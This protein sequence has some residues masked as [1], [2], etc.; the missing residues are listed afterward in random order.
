VST[1]PLDL[2]EFPADFVT[3]S[4]YKIFGFPTGLGALLVRRDSCRLLHKRYFGG[5]TV[6]GTVSRSGLHVP[7]LELHERLEDGTVP[8]LEILALE[9]GFQTL[10]RLAGPLSLVA[11]HTFSLAKYVHDEL[12]AMTHYNGAPVA[13]V[14]CDGDFSDPSVQGAILNF[15]L[16]RANGAYVG[17]SEVSDLASVHDIHLRTGCFCNTGACMTYL[18]MDTPHILRHMKAG[19]VCGDSIDLV[20]GRPTGSVRISFG[21]MSTLEDTKTF[22]SFIAH[23]FRCSSENRHSDDV[24]IRHNDVMGKASTGDYI[25][26]E[27]AVRREGKWREG[28]KVLTVG[29]GV[30]AFSDSSVSVA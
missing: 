16:L 17:Y 5:G 15:N 9:H 22:V 10:S 21:Y 8:F 3:I 30:V 29:A 27:D 18:R 24:I 11:E 28:E 20:D 26:A 13:V 6:F 7:R 1:N 14:Y 12:S 2:S 23:N 4:F 19:H 25:A